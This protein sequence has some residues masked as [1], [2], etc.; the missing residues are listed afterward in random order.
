MPF[1]ILLFCL[2]GYSE[3]LI[4]VFWNFVARHYCFLFIIIFINVRCFYD[5]VNS[6][7][8]LSIDISSYWSSLRWTMIFL[9]SFKLNHNDNLGLSSTLSIFDT[10]NF[11]FET[12]CRLNLFFLLF[13]EIVT[14][15]IFVYSLPENP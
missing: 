14:Y 11:L 3:A 12:K 8:C 7:K 4:L 1:N 5:L 15:N 13:E 10:L 6:S 2:K 9:I